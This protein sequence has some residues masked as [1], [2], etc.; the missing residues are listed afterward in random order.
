M[1]VGGGEAGVIAIE[2][3]RGPRRLLPF[4]L[5]ASVVLVV[6]V[7]VL[8][9]VRSIRQPEAVRGGAD[10]V[11]LLAPA[12]DVAASA[13]I[14]FAWRPVSGA[15]RYELQLLDAQGSPRFRAATTDTTA[16]S[17]TP[18]AGAYRWLVRALL[19]GGAEVTSPARPLRVR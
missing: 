3:R 6:G 18:P 12:E 9:R 16:A 19:D 15:R 8:T 1:P 2:S 14:V 13:R 5:A 10:A 11:V 17:V 4:A 7:G